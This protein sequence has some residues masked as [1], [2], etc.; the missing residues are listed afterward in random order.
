M[1]GILRKW[2]LSEYYT[3]WPLYVFPPLSM[4]LFRS[5]VA[6]S[7]TFPRQ[8]STAVKAPA[9]IQH[10]RHAFVAATTVANSSSERLCRAMT[11]SMS[12]LSPMAHVWVPLSAFIEASVIRNDDESRRHW[13]SM[14]WS[15]VRGVVDSFASFSSS[16]GVEEL[17]R[18]IRETASSTNAPKS[19]GGIFSIGG[20]S[21]GSG[22]PSRRELMLMDWGKR[23]VGGREA[24]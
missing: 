2:A 20:K 4:T 13:Q 5:L 21:K 22:A 19:V 1:K 24:I 8:S 14:V 3:G 7:R 12:L 15:I 18:V 10:S 11:I 16:C 23:D 6:C 17:A 9:A